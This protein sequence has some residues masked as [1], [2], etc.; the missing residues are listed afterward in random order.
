MVKILLILISAA[1]LAFPQQPNEQNTPPNP[2]RPPSIANIAYGPYPMN[3]LDLYLAKSDKPTPLV[4]Y[5]FPGGFVVGNKNTVNTFL[6]DACNK[7]GITVASINYRYSTQAPF[8]ALFHDAARALQFLRLHAKEYNI[9]PQAIASTGSSAGADIS[10]WL[11]FHKDLAD[12]SSSDPV[13][14]QSTRIVAVGAAAAQTTLDPRVLVK[15]VGEEGASNPAFPKL[16]GLKR[17]EMD[18]ERAHKLYEEASAS[19]LLTKDAAPVFLYYSMPNKPVSPQTP[20]GE[21]MHHPIFGFYLKEQMD[22]TGV[23]CVMHLKDDYGDNP[24]PLWH[25]DMVRFFVKHFPSK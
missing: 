15:L 20:Q 3:D 9:D 8:P 14:R 12:P 6:L 23:E 22:K 19:A 25:Q 24:G 5:F 1:G 17:D 10:L 4:M 16:Y 21:R 18:T 11:G 2:P 13:L 7:A